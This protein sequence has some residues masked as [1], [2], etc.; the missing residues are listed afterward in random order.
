MWK[1]LLSVVRELDINTKK[2]IFKSHSTDNFFT[3]SIVVNVD[4]G[5]TTL[6]IFESDQ[7]CPVLRSRFLKIQC[8]SISYYNEE[9]FNIVEN[10]GY[11]IIV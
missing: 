2:Y 4:T 3:E 9:S 8:D 7:G 1:S 11:Q 5:E 6:K 10:R